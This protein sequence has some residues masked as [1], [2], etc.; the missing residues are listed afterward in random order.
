VWACDAISA[1]IL[2]WGKWGFIILYALTFFFANF[3]PNATTFIV[4]VELFSTRYRSSL[5]GISAA[6]GAVLLAL[7]TEI[8]GFSPEVW[9]GLGS[10]VDCTNTVAS[11]PRAAV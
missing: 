2:H 5:H 7:I 11:A 4:P 3:G 1:Q 8:R 10:Q 6:S 9:E